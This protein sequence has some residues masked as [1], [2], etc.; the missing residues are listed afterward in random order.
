MDL[1]TLQFQQPHALFA[2][3]FAQMALWDVNQDD[4]FFFPPFI[5]LDLELTLTSAFPCISDDF[6]G[7]FCL[8]EF[9]LKY[10]I[11]VKLIHFRCQQGFI[12]LTCLLH[13]IKIKSSETSSLEGLVLL[14]TIA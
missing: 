14:T 13:H 12:L 9:H 1:P 3:L 11:F 5:F 4:V 2:A 7:L 6:M 8:G 10:S